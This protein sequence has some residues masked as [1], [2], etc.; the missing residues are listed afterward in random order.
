M[1]FKNSLKDSTKDKLSSSLSISPSNVK[2]ADSKLLHSVTI[3]INGETVP[4]EKIGGL[5]FKKVVHT[6]NRP[7][8]WHQDAHDKPDWRLKKNKWRKTEDSSPN[9]VPHSASMPN[10]NA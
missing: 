1:R 2:Y 5:T 6:I 3:S 4:P 10:D 8:M 7:C 9:S